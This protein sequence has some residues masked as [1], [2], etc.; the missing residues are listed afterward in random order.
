MKVKSLACK[1]NCRLR[2]NAYT[3]IDGELA[4]GYTG[5]LTFF[6][7]GQF[8]RE[9]CGR[10]NGESIAASA[11]NMFTSANINTSSSIKFL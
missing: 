9:I 1:S 5:D 2:L 8:F 6:K 7:A 10:G 3:S 11:E 4:C